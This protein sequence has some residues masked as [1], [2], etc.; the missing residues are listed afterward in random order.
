M[1][2][3]K[4]MQPETSQCPEISGLLP[5]LVCMALHAPGHSQIHP[6]TG[7]SNDIN[8]HIPYIQHP[9]RTSIHDFIF[10]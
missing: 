7:L 1:L 8:T 9:A 5:W 4:H 10:I 3:A 2:Q 6:V